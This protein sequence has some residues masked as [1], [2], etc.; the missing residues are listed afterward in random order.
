MMNQGICNG[1]LGRAKINFFQ[2]AI[3]VG[4]GI[5]QANLP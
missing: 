5:R 1:Q 4:Y 3:S 2:D